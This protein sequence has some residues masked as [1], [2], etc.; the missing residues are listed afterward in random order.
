MYDALCDKGTCLETTPDGAPMQFDYG[1][2]T[3]KGSEILIAKV[4][5]QFQM[6]G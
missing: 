3:L 2:L 4:R 6:G 1:H 5:D